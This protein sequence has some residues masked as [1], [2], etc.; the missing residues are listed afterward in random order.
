MRLNLHAAVRLATLAAVVLAGAAQADERR[1]ADGTQLSVAVDKDANRLVLQWQPAAGTVREQA[2]AVRGQLLDG[3]CLFQRNGLAGFYTFND[4]GYLAQWLLPALDA[5]P[6]LVRQVP[7]FVDILD[8]HVDDNAGQLYVLEG[9]VG[10]SRLASGEGSMEAELLALYPPHGK[11]DP[12][13]ETFSVAGSE[14]RVGER[15]VAAL[16]TAHDSLPAV[17]AAGQT[18]PVPTTGDAADDPAIWVDPQT[19]TVRILGTDKRFGLRVYDLEGSELQAIATGR[20]NNVDLRP[21]SGGGDVVALAAASNRSLRSI[22]LFSID[23]SGNLGWLRD[24]DIATGLDDPYGLCMY[25][26]GKHLQVFVNDKDGRLQQWR[27]RPGDGGY[28]GEL[29]R[30]LQLPDQPEGCVADDQQHLLF[31]GIEDM[32]VYTLPT[33][34]L[35]AEPQRLAAVDDETLHAD[36]E[37]MA[38]YPVGAAGFLVVSS[39][40]NHSYAVFERQPPHRYRGSFQVTDNLGAQV[41]GASETDGLDITAAALGERFPEGLLVVQDGYNVLPDGNQN[42]K[43]VDWRAVREA[44]DL[45]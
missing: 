31:F 27:L 28:S 20:L 6:Q 45:P 40:G 23:A 24:S 17:P 25:D 33:D 21:L 29:L 19:G 8:C 34:V 15:T 30:E 42:F 1:L 41:D 39:Q 11:L 44:L 14:L 35:D 5:Q 16:A 18:A 38:L 2:I 32:G 43:L 12:E 3:A 10:V 26:D 9:G 36:V 37:G 22:S 7:G 4:R 13:A